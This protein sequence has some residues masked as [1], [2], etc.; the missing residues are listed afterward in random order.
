MRRDKALWGMLAGAA[1]AALAS[2]YVVYRR[3]RKAT[4][5]NLRDQ[6][7]LLETRC[8]PVQFAAV[9]RG[10]A[11]LLLHGGGGGYDNA[12]VFS[13]PGWGFRFISVSRP[14][15]LDTPLQQAGSLESEVEL[16][17]ALLDELG[18]ERAAIIGMSGGGP[19]AITFAARYPERTWGLV[20][21]SAIS[22]MM[23]EFPGFMES[24]TSLGTRSDFIPW[25]L[26]NTPLFKIVDRII[27]SNL[28]QQIGD[29]PEKELM[30]QETM[31]TM[32]PLGPRMAGVLAD[33][34]HIAH[35]KDL[36]LESV[37]APTLVI[38]GD[39]DRIVPYENGQR[40]AWLIPNVEL[41]RLEG[42]DHFGFITHMEIAA[43]RLENFLRKHAPEQ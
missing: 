8:G 17:A 5:Q 32:F 20:L 43:P 19:A 18:V 34:H 38:H 23:N 31:H 16:Y 4:L 15:Y 11:V 14:G 12:L 21:L 7:E 33:L 10:P 36:P 35:A 6:S 13:F 41:V 27:G 3:E 22:G 24:I 25:L 39:A 37:K 28:S 42:A 2:A 40:S 9:G 26:L 1:T 29:D 30:L